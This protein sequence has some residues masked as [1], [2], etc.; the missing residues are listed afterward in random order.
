MFR[1]I[2]FYL[3]QLAHLII[4]MDLSPRNQPLEMLAMVISQHSMHAALQLN[5]LFNAAMEDYQPEMTNG[6]KNE[7]CNPFYFARCARLIQD[8]ERAIIF[9]D[10]EAPPDASALNTPERSNAT[11]KTNDTK[12]GL[13]ERALRNESSHGSIDGILNGQLYYKRLERKSMFHTKTWKQLYFVVDQR[14]LLCYREPHAVHPKRAI[15]LQNCRV[16]VSPTSDKYG[17]TLFE[18]VNESNSARYLLRAETSEARAKWV[19]FLEK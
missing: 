5:F 7:A 10:H 19:T 4:H 15:P 8:I 13:I 18:L 16:L 14:V 2:E 3:P 17:D 11:R 9:G 1:S 6:Q 12:I